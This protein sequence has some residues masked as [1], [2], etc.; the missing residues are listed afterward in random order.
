MCVY[1]VG[2]TKTRT[3][4][5]G[6]TQQENTGLSGFYLVHLSQVTLPTKLQYQTNVILC[7]HFVLEN[8]KAFV[9]I[10]VILS[11]EELAILP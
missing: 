10:N 7:E 1:R 5:R 3:Q 4:S 6:P 9:S 11:A 2:T 8:E